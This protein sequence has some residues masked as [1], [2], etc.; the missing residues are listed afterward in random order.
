M[1]I[2]ILSLLDSG[3]W[4]PHSGTLR[5]ELTRADHRYIYIYI[6][7]YP[8]VYIYIY[9]YIY[10]YL[11]NPI[12]SP[13]TVKYECP[14]LSLLIITSDLETNNIEPRSYLIIPC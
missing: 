8:C 13:L 5:L 10:L 4:A 9:I 3:V 14:Q 11:T 6:C 1:Y 2:C 12:V 7:I